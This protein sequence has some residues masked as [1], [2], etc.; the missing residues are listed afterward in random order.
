M[1]KNKFAI[2]LLVAMLM[3]GTT[4]EAKRA[5]KNKN[6]TKSAT[7]IETKESTPLTEVLKE[8]DELVEKA[9]SR[10]KAKEAIAAKEASREAEEAS[11]DVPKAISHYTKEHP[12]PVQTLISWTPYNMAVAYEFQLWAGVRQ[13]GKQQAPPVMIFDTR[14]VYTNIYDIDLES[15]AN[16]KHLAWRVRALDL[17]KMP[18]SE[19][20]AYEPL[21]IDS[22]KP[23]ID[24]P[25]PLADYDSSTSNGSV[26]LYPVY[27]FVAVPG[28][29]KYE[30]EVLKEEPENP[31]GT[32][33]SKNRIWSKTFTYTDIYDDVPR[34]GSQPFFW[35]V[36]ALDVQD[37]I[38]GTYSPTRQF[39][40]DPKATWQVGVFGDSISHGG[41]DMSYSPA[42]LTYSWV[43]YLQTPAV[44]LSASG[45]TSASLLARFDHDVLPFS[46]HYL[47]IM[48]GT[49]S[50][51]GDASAEDVISDLAAIKEKCLANNIKPIFLTLL[52]INP[53]NIQKCFQ[54][55]SA[56]DWQ[57]KFAAVNKYIRTQVHVDVAAAMP[58]GPELLPTDMGI[59]G[60]HPTALVKRIIGETVNAQWTTVTKEADGE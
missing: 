15:Y 36:K 45:D 31:E 25:M 30:V 55:D 34:M 21:Y 27:N 20:S 28:A 44:N 39:I 37:K 16:A 38:I 41:G 13:D 59:D 42:D 54:E 43:H 10:N 6:K 7:K 35:R 4:G 56:E 47:L 50:L 29:V 26:L 40:T 22:T 2:L 5:D 51:R 52:P 11:S 14:N 12:S 58:F 49:N 17:D 3:V 48:G 60:L 32:T 24:Y 23:G 46:P 18:I 33:D 9:G 53:A 8:Q 19:F 57:K 1:K